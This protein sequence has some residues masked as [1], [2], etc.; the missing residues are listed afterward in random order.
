M[1]RVKHDR[2][3]GDFVPSKT[4]HF[5]NQADAMGNGCSDSWWTGGNYGGSLCRNPAHHDKQ[6]CTEGCGREVY[7]TTPTKCNV[8]W[9]ASVP[10]A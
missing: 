2:R 1:S 9:N 6:P 10:N 8:C 3:S 4:G 7:G 5:C